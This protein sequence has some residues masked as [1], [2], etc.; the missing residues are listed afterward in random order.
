[1]TESLYLNGIRGTLWR[2]PESGWYVVTIPTHE[3][4]M[5]ARSYAQ[6]IDLWTGAVAEITGQG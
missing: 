6:A 5:E 1:M 3:R 2:D 4:S